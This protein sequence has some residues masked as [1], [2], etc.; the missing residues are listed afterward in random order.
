MSFPFMS[1]YRLLHFLILA[2]WS[3]PPILY[4]VA[5]LSCIHVNQEGIVK[6]ISYRIVLF[7][8]LSFL[9]LLFA[10]LGLCCCWQAFSRSLVVASLVGEHRF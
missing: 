3:G 7:A 6:Y 9:L 1:L 2:H 10:A 4:V 8:L 5:V